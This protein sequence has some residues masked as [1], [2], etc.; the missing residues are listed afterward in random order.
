MKLEN[1]CKQI[2]LQTYA[3]KYLKENL[4]SSQTGVLFMEQGVHKAGYVI[5][6]SDEAVI[7]NS[8]RLQHLLKL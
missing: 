8:P 6:T 4:D 3:A 7:E 1:D 2:V 5:I